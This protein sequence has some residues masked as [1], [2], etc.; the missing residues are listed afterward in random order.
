MKKE[1]KIGDNYESVKR[2]Q[3]DEFNKFIIQLKIVYQFKFLA[4]K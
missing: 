4:N 1:V 2:I 3:T